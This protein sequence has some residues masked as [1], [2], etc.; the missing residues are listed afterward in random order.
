MERLLQY[1]FDGLSLGSIYALLALGL[2]VVFRGTGHL[3]FAQ[4]EMAMICTFFTWQFHAWGLPLVVSVL[5]GM[6]SGFVLG[7]GVE[8]SLIRRVAKKSEAGVFVVS[9]AM[10][11]GFNSLAGMIWGNLPPE[12]M[13]SLFPDEPDDFVKIFGAVWRYEYIGIMIVA[14]LLMGLLFVLFAK[15]KFGLA[16]RAVASNPESARLVG[17]PTGVVLAAS[18][19]IAAAMGALSGAMVGGLAGELTSLL[20]F[21]P[22][23][24]ASASATLG[25]FDSPGGAVI[26]GLAIGVGEQL[27]AGYAPG[28]IGQELRLGVALV[29]I[30]VVLLFKP[31]G[32]FGSTKVERV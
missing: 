7:A 8:V 28:W 31:S 19:G 3:N 25:G 17:I 16:M 22:F 14:L 23:I 11:L 24:Y 27:A 4:G 29:T 15:T 10:F 1:V 12:E 9:I 32:L 2:V 21:T 13:P 26:A 20:M 18:W 5:L 30:F 6:V